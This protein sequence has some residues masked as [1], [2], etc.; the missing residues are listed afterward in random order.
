M[1]IFTDILKS[2]VEDV[3]ENTFDVSEI[4]MNRVKHL[5]RSDEE[6]ELDKEGEERRP[7]DFNYNRGLRLSDAKL[8]APGQPGVYVL[9][10]NGRVMKCGRAAYCQGLRWRFTQ[11]YNLNY[12][13]RA[14]NGD[15]WS[16]NLSNR[17]SII[18]SWQACP[19]SKCKELEYKL[20]KK[21]GKGPWGL[22]APNS[23]NVDTWELLI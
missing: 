21:Y 4:D 23:C 5:R 14:R 1:G 6:L 19:V 22:R 8:C 18:V 11:Y 7:E 9:Y 17:D 3:V 10:L 16:V 2:V 20:F 15:C 13:D 12:D